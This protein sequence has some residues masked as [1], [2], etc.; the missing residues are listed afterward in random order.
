MDDWP[1]SY[2]GNLSRRG[3]YTPNLT[4]HKNINLETILPH[5]APGHHQQAGRTANIDDQAVVGKL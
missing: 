3:V 1:G 4:A 2:G 5:G